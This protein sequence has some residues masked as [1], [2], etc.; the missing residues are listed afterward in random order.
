MLECR[1]F[2]E[3]WLVQGLVFQQLYSLYVVRVY[4]AVSN[5][6]AKS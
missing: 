1:G 4:S 2:E 6:S 3:G 5:L